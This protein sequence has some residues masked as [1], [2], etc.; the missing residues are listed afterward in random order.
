MH[1]RHKTTGFRF[2]MDVDYDSWQGFWGVGPYKPCKTCD[3]FVSLVRLNGNVRYERVCIGPKKCMADLQKATPKK[4]SK[5]DTASKPAAGAGSD[6]PRVAW[7]GEHFRKRFYQTRI[8]E[9]FSDV[10]PET[11]TA[12]AWPCSPC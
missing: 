2:E 10:R 7:P 8:P 3:N 1:R 4:E 6:A 12:A 9:R 5:A 11:D